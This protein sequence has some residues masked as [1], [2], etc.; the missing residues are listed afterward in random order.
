[1][2]AR[3]Y[4]V[5]GH[6]HSGTMAPPRASNNQGK[7]MVSLQTPVCE[8]GKAA[9]TLTCRVSTAVH[10]SRDQCMGEKACW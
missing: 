3:F 9:P 5:E 4:T 10:W 8:F 7:P 2:G 6:A 1:M